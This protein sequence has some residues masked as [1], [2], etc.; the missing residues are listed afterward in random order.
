MIGGPFGDTGLAG[1]K[2]IVDTYGGAIPHGGGTFDL[3]P[4]GM[5]EALSLRKP[6]FAKTAVYGHFN[7]EQQHPWEQLAKLESFVTI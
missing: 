3:S 5:I 2:I 1:R 6:I 4:K 7:M